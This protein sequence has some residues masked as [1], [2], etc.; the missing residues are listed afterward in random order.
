MLDTAGPEEFSSLRDQWIRDCEGFVI[1]YSITSRPS[2]EQTSAFFEQALRVK[3]LD[4]LPFVLC[5]NKADL[6]EAREVTT[7]EGKDQ[8]K[9][10]EATFFETSAK[11]NTNIHECYVEMARSIRRERKGYVNCPKAVVDRVILLLLLARK[12][13]PKS[14]LASLDKNVLQLI[15]KDVYETRHDRELWK[16]LIERERALQD[17]GAKPKK[18]CIVM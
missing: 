6:E 3:D 10:F 2:F 17:D 5:G 18:K 14:S 1:L 15:L 9:R 12:S 13:D 7:Q 8:A 4:H 16:P 11:T